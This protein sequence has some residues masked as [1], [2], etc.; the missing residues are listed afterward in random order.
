MCP[1]C[2]KKDAAFKATLHIQGKGEV[3]IKLC[4]LHDVEL[5][6]KGQIKF[7]AQYSEQISSVLGPDKKSAVEEYSFN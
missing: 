2:R 7:Q 6:K 1:I 4:Y 5:F 3:V